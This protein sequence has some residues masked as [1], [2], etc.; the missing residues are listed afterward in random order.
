MGQ[1]SVGLQQLALHVVMFKSCLPCYTKTTASPKLSN[2]LPVFAAAAVAV[3]VTSKT[4]RT[5]CF[6]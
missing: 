2:M 1:A 5:K 6:V 3:G 4:A